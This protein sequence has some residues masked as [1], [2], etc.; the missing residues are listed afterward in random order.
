MKLEKF[1]KNN[2]IV[3]Y[4]T[5][6]KGERLYYCSKCEYVIYGDK[7]QKCFGCGK[8]V[9]LIAFNM[10]IGEKDFNDLFPLLKEG[11]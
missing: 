10:K 7:R 3:G 8:R 2:P 4:T 6:G 1:I 9:R 11:E 5:I